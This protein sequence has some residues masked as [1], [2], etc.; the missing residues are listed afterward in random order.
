MTDVLWTGWWGFRSRIFYFALQRSASL[1]LNGYGRLFYRAFSECVTSTADGGEWSAS[2]FTPL[3][4]YPQGNIRR[5]VEHRKISPLARNQTSAVQP[6]ARCHTD[7]AILALVTTHMLLGGRRQHI[8]WRCYYEGNGNNTFNP[9]SH[10]MQLR[11]IIS[12]KTALISVPF[13]SRPNCSQSSGNKT[14][15]GIKNCSLLQLTSKT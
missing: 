1:L 13:D 5:V 2:R 6:I 3:P 11:H 14:D 8:P 10:Q 12:T 7:W 15:T 9:R 4:V